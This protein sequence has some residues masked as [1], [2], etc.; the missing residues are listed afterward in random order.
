MGRASNFAQI[1]SMIEAI[2][3]APRGK[4]GEAKLTDEFWGQELP[5]PIPGVG[6]KVKVT[7]TYGVT[8]T[9]STWRRGGQPEVRH[10][11]RGA[12]RVPRAAAREGHLLPGMKRKP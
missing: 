4:E 11:V 7:G 1:Y 5:N 10:H 12:D 2:D 8:F 3:Q 9:K 6:A